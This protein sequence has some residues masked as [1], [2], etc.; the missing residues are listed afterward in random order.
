MSDF[1][2]VRAGRHAA[3]FEKFTGGIC[4]PIERQV[5]PS[6]LFEIESKRVVP[7]VRTYWP[8]PTDGEPS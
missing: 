6:K 3:D 7:L 8:L 4:I 2:V 5:E 1:W